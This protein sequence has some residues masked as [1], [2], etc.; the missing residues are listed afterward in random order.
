MSFAWGRI[1]HL[2]GPRE[3]QRR[4]VPQVALQLLRG[5]PVDTTHGDQLRDFLHVEDVASGLVELAFSGLEG[6]V[7]ISS[8]HPVTVGEVVSMI[9][10]L[11]GRHDLVR[12][13]ARPESPGDLRF[14]CGCNQRLTEATAWHPTIDLAG[15]LD[16]TVQWWRGRS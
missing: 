11:T 4:F 5:L 10:N 12:R 14:L 8:G 7:N 3:D 15:G 13:G 2:Y 16:Q 1:F 9:E 6:A